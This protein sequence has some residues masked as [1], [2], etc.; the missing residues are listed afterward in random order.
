MSMLLGLFLAPLL[1]GLIH[2]VKAFF[3]GRRG[4]P[5]LQ[6]YWDLARLVRKHMVLSRTTTP[7]FLLGPA[8]SLVS[9]LAC[10]AL[11]PL[12]GPALLHFPGDLLVF[13]GL[14]ALVRFATVLAAMDTGS[15]FEGMGASREVAIGA[16]AEPGIFL[17]L[18]VLVVQTRALSLSGI[19]ARSGPEL[20]NRAGLVMV[21][22]GIA[23]FLLLL[24]E[25]SR[26]P[27]DD[28][29]THLELTMIHEVMVLDHSGPALAAIEYASA[30]KLWIGSLLLS[31]LL[32]PLHSGSAWLDLLGGVGV[33]FLVALAVGLVEST[34]A[35]LSMLRVPQ[36]VG[37]SSALSL[38]ALFLV[39]R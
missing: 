32:F 24:A 22:V 2:R 9:L 30:L 19:W 17:T 6:L 8:L 28:P 14:L 13:L 39:I 37:L 10:L 33:V 27:V 34:S 15:S 26:I 25:N 3:A 7:V 11:I 23:L 31:S 18:A 21:L 20:W 29:N 12:G 36:F 1:A 16:L 4:R 38:L 35:R 5:L